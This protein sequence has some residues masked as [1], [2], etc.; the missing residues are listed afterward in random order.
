MATKDHWESVYQ[1]KGDGEVSWTQT[2]PQLSL[3]LISEA[4]P[5]GS[6]IDIGGGAS[7]LVDRLLDAGYAAAVLDISGAALERSR[8]R[9]GERAKDV[10]WIVADVTADPDVGQYDLWHDR[11]VFHFL[12]EPADRAAYV[13]MLSRSV[14]VGGHAVVATFALDGP[15]SCSGLPVR[16]YD[17]RALAAE[18]GVG[19]RLLKS[20]SETH[21]TPSGKPQSFQYSVF[22]RQ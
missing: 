18:L 21:V 10:R 22:R 12:T 9:L 15:Q 5:G 14:R 3:S 19:F 6:V 8:A 13:S 4:L 1:T 17:G 7:V 16:R 20:V 11:A 2:D